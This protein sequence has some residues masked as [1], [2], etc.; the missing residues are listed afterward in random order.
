MD[1]CVVMIVHNEPTI[2]QPAPKGLM[3]HAYSNTLLKWVIVNTTRPQRD[4]APC[5]HSNTLLKCVTV[6]PSSAESCFISAAV[7]FLL[8]TRGRDGDN[9][10]PS[11]RSFTQQWSHGRP[12][13]Q[14]KENFRTKQRVHNA[15]IMHT[16]L[17]YPPGVIIIDQCVFIH[18]KSPGRL[19]LI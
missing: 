6:S 11:R 16:S 13:L 7:D 5:V 4:N 2:T 17:S 14:N 3:R 18:S 19:L 15:H 12:F 9:S 10:G 8:A 1:L